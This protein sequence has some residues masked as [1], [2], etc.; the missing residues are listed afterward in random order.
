MRTGKTTTAALVEGEAGTYTARLK[1]AKLAAVTS[2]RGHAER[3]RP[4][5]AR[6]QLLY[7]TF[8]V[9]CVISFSPSKVQTAGFPSITVS[10]C[11]GRPQ[12]L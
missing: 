9:S 3:Q 10:R 11:T 5:R 4:L 12:S 6:P 1:V 2:D 8:S 7:P